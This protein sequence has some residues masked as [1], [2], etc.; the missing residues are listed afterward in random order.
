MKRQTHRTYQVLYCDTGT[1]FAFLRRRHNRRPYLAIHPDYK[2]NIE[3]TLDCLIALTEADKTLTPAEM[4]QGCTMFITR[5]FNVG[6]T[7]DPFRIAKFIK[8]I[9]FQEP[10]PGFS[11]N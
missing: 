2:G 10:T 11:P 6:K 8:P 9:V 5:Q 4:D 7:R 3:F 1:A